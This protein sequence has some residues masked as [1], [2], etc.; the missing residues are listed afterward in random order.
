MVTPSPAL[1]PRPASVPRSLRD[2]EDAEQASRSGCSPLGAAPIGLIVPSPLGGDAGI[3]SV[4]SPNQL[5]E[6]AR[7]NNPQTPSGRWCDVNADE[8]GVLSPGL[9][10][11]IYGGETSAA[12]SITQG[13]REARPFVARISDAAG[14]RTCRSTERE[15]ISSASEPPTPTAAMP[16]AGRGSLTTGATMLSGAA[17]IHPIR[18]Q[19]QRAV[20]QAGARLRAGPMKRVGLGG[21]G[22]VMQCSVVAWCSV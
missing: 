1:G 3:V 21:S 11:T 5:C 20:G 13:L 4:N 9:D 15:G 6:A 12:G 8:I 16:P 18:Q 19:L 14:G 10:G 17:A 22:F 2:V 7:Q